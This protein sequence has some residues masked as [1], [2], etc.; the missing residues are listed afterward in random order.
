ML[1]MNQSIA[2][3]SVELKTVAKAYQSGA[4]RGED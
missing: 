4:L 2:K 3:Q 1:A